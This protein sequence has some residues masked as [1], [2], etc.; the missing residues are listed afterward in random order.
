MISFFH[1][2]L[3][4]HGHLILDDISFEVAPGEF[5]CIAGE[6][7]SGKTSI[8]EL[9]LSLEKPSKGTVSVDEIDLSSLPPKF[10]RVYR[11]SIGYLPQED[12]LLAH[13][14]VAVNIALPLTIRGMPKS[15]I[16]QHVATLLTKMNLLTKA[17]LFPP[18]L[19][20]ADRKKTALARALIG[21][22][23]ILLADEPD[24][25]AFHLLTERNHSGVTVLLLTSHASLIE[26]LCARTLRLQKGKLTR[27]ARLSSPVHAHIP[28][29]NV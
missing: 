25:L 18:A 8:A 20:H 9:L 27:D 17:A 26:R 24:P 11:Q 29:T 13:E 4:K 7:G 5:V 6:S 10:L 19:S 2:S 22:P 12:L 14:T 3:R 23:A 15:E 1:V 21:E 16:E 28:L